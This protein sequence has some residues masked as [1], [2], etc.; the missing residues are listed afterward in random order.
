MSIYNILY[1]QLTK[2]NISNKCDNKLEQYRMDT[3]Q[4]IK[5]MN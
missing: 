2:L 5:S 3:I 4:Q 1:L